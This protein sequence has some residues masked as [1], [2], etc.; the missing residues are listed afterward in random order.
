MLATYPRKSQH[1]RMRFCFFGCMLQIDNS[2]SRMRLL[3][4]LWSVGV[5]VLQA[6]MTAADI[7]GDHLRGIVFGTLLNWG[8]VP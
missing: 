2:F 3:E 5:L 8:L 1:E 7:V 6:S 4:W